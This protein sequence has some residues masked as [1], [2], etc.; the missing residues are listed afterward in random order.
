[1]AAIA[2]LCTRGLLLDRG[3]LKFSGSPQSVLEEYLSKSRVTASVSLA[4]RTD[5]NGVGRVRFSN[6]SVLNDRDE[7]VATVFS[8]QDISI[9]LD[10][11]IPA[12]ETLANATVQIKFTGTFGQPLFACLS[13]SSRRESLLLVPG[14]RLY[15]HIPPSPNTGWRL[16]ICDMV[17]GR[18]NVGGLRVG[19][20]C[21]LSCRGGLFKNG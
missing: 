16:C 1:M 9:L 20:R 13:R 17:F 19:R 2:S 7:V 15:C 10:Y 18:R 5:R 11:E 12:S 14:A 21:D 3:R 4:A 8:G 6:V